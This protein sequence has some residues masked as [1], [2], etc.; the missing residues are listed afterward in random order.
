M[1]MM[2]RARVPIKNGRKRGQR[3]ITDQGS[4]S[5]FS[6]LCMHGHAMSNS[7]VV[8]AR[9]FLRLSWPTANAEEE[10]EEI[11]GRERRGTCIW[12]FFPLL[13]S[14]FCHAKKVGAAE[15][16][17]RSKKGIGACQARTGPKDRTLPPWGCLLSWGAKR[18]MKRLLCWEIGRRGEG[19]EGKNQDSFFFRLLPFFRSGQPR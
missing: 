6:Y 5:V 12:S 19:A 3:R 15:R 16:L 9:G 7:M 17:G 2:I 10:E 18:E 11:G 4:P 1:T 8:A 13:S 14:S